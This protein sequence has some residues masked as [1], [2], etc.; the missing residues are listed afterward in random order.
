MTGEPTRTRG[1]GE[2]G[3]WVGGGYEGT[4]FWVDPKREFVGV[5][6]GTVDGLQ[7]AFQS[8]SVGTGFTWPR[9]FSS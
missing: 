1:E 4:H 9:Y 3:L 7:I 5:I 2:E 6:N 8:D